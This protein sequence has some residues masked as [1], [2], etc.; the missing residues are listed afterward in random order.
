MFSGLS[1]SIPANCVSIREASLQLLWYGIN[2]HDQCCGVIQHP[3]IYL[4]DFCQSSDRDAQSQFST[5]VDRETLNTTQSGDNYETTRSQDTCAEM[6]EGGATE[7]P[8]DDITSP[9]VPHDNKSKQQRLKHLFLLT[10]IKFKCF[11]S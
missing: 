11:L 6:E 1:L 10:V 3:C 8:T 5:D 2:Y 9:A 7:T 4:A